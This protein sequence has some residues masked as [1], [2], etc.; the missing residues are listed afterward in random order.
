M[1]NTCSQSS[2]QLISGVQ[3]GNED[4][5]VGMGSRQPHGCLAGRRE[6]GPDLKILKGVPHLSSL[7]CEDQCL[8]TII[9]DQ[10]DI[11]SEGRV[12]DSEMGNEALYFRSCKFFGWGEPPINWLPQELGNP[13]TPKNRA[14]VRSGDVYGIVHGKFVRETCF[15][16][17]LVSSDEF[18]KMHSIVVE[19][20]PTGSLGR[21]KRSN[22]VHYS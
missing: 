1:M 22:M 2:W 8:R 10:M 3:S 21:D 4:L 14:A 9:F 5:H 16:W 12:S 20:S 6:S 13:R 11:S 19:R 17:E 15:P 18:T 7:P